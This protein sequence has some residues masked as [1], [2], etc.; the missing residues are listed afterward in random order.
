MEPRQDMCAESEPEQR[1]ERQSSGEMAAAAVCGAVLGAGIL[2]AAA[3]LWARGNAGGTDA[4]P[5]T[6][7]LAAIGALSG[8]AVVLAYL[9]SD[10]AR[11]ANDQ[12][13]V[14]F[15]VEDYMLDLAPLT[16]MAWQPIPVAVPQ[17][18]AVSL[19]ALPETR[20]LRRVQRRPRRSGR[21][22]HPS[23]RRVARP[24]RSFQR[25]PAEA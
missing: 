13:A 21:A 15:I 7:V 4:I 9:R 18:E 24:A 20:R 12:A 23:V 1:K 5:L 22:S 8:A 10:V 11:P 25:P 6:Y 3:E 2:F 19:E 16:P 17:L 14:R